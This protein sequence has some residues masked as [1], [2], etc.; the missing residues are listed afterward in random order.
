M[1]CNINLLSIDSDEYTKKFV[2]IMLSNFFQPHILQPSRVINDNKPSLIYNMFLNSIEYEK[3]NGNVISK[4]SDHLPSLMFCKSI[5]MKTKS[6]TRSLYCD[7]SNFKPD[8]NIHD[9]KKAS[10]NEKQN[11]IE[12]ATALYNMFNEILTPN[13]QKHVP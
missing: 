3:L 1:D 12:E 5:N 13:L 10:Q 7:Y 11:L 9:L 6:K 8:S 2:N 4:I